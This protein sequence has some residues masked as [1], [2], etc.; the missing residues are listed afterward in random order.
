MHFAAAAR[1]RLPSADAGR[2]LGALLLSLGGAVLLLLAVNLALHGHPLP[3]SHSAPH[4]WQAAPPP[5]HAPERSVPFSPRS[6]AVPSRGA[7]PGTAVPVMALGMVAAFLLGV[8]STRSLTQPTWER[9]NDARDG[10]TRW[11]SAGVPDADRDAASLRDAVL[12]SGLAVLA[13]VLVARG[14]LATANASFLLSALLTASGTPLL[15]GGTLALGGV[16][17]AYPMLVRGGGPDS[18]RC[19]RGFLAVQFALSVVL[20]AAPMA[21]VPTSSPVPPPPAPDAPV[22]VTE[23]RPLSGAPGGGHRPLAA[24]R[25]PAG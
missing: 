13:G 6:A 9:R 16:A 15:L 4:T 20:V 10:R 2:R 14:L 23:A 1:S 22:L 17:G 11:Q 3:A 5:V 19:R 8:G 24:R 7:L 21:F 25:H 12:L 18:S